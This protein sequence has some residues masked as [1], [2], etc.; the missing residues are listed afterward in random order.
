MC[1]SREVEGE[2]L[3]LCACDRILLLLLLD[4]LQGCCRCLMLVEEDAVLVRVAGVQVGLLFEHLTDESVGEKA[5]SDDL[6]CRD[7]LRLI[8]TVATSVVACPQ[9]RLTSEDKGMHPFFV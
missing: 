3:L 8:T 7:T 6:D 1:V 5:P 9:V 2:E 4:C